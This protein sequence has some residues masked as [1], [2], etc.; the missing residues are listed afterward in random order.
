[1]RLYVV[2][3]I[4]RIDSG[5]LGDRTVRYPAYLEG[6][7]NPSPVAELIGLQWNG[8][9]FGAEPAMLIMCD[10]TSAQHQTLGQQVDVVAVPENLD[11]Q[12]GAQLNQV[13]NAME[14]FNIPCQ[15]VQATHTY[16]QVIRLCA[17]MFQFAQR[18]HGLGG[19]RIFPPGVTLDTRFN[20][21][22]VSARNKLQGTAESMNFDTSSLTG[23]STLRQILKAMGDQCGQLEIYLG[24]VTL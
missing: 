13:K 23:A 5:P 1:M 16:R 10:P 4:T 18:F 24:G 8:M 9:D 11:S 2:P 17:A 19:G 14:Q 7:W 22:P 6:Q 15:W 20:Q 21:L 12:I 3:I